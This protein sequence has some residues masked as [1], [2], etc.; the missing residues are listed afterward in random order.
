MGSGSFVGKHDNRGQPRKRRRY[1]AKKT[2]SHTESTIMNDVYEADDR[3]AEEELG[4]NRRF[5][6]R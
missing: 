3:V 1:S 2:L 5:D 4:N 6:V